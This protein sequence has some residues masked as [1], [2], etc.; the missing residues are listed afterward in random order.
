MN[1]RM[2]DWAKRKPYD[3]DGDKDSS[4]GGINKYTDTFTCTNTF[5]NLFYI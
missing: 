5:T 1:G 2:N 3:D 4:G